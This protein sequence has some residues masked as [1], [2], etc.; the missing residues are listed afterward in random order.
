MPEVKQLEMRAGPTRFSTA[1][2][3]RQRFR[4]PLYRLGIPLGSHDRTQPQPLGPHQ[5]ARTEAS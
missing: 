5:P 3:D 4:R 2:R 1:D